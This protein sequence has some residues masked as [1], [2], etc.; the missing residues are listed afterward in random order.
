MKAAAD[1]IRRNGFLIALGAAAFFACLVAAAPASIV[2]ALINLDH[3]QVAYSSVEGS[4]WDGEIRNLTVSGVAIGDVTYRFSPV[5]LLSLAPR[6]DVAVR[7]GAVRGKGVMRVGFGPRVELADTAVDIDLAPFARRGIMGAPV[8]G[9]A[10][11]SVS[12]L[13]LTRAGCQEAE[14]RLWTDVLDAPVRR[15]RGADFPMAGAA[16]CSGDDLVAVLSGDN[17]DGSVELELRVRPDL[18]YELAATARL[19]E[20]ELAS[21]LKVFGFEDSNGALVYGSAGVLRGV[22]S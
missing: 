21:A 20:E 13:V 12:R 4:V 15:F 16:R 14:A 5:S 10:Q 22:G 8:E 17:A 18:S 3:R 6:I 9:M 2:P 1:H 7:D 19:E 11:V